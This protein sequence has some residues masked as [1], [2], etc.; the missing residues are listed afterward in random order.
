MSKTTSGYSKK[1]AEYQRKRRAKR[2]AEGLCVQCGKVKATGSATTGRRY[3]TCSNCRRHVTN[4]VAAHR[5]GV[6][7]N[8]PDDDERGKPHPFTT[9]GKRYRVKK[10]RRTGV[11]V[12]CPCPDPIIIQFG[13]KPNTR[14]VFHLRECE[15]VKHGK[16]VE[17]KHL[18][19]IVPILEHLKEVKQYKNKVH[20]IKEVL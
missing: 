13:E 12:P 16:E 5:E 4:R 18:I 15:E 10:T 20:S 11:I 19:G 17:R 1:Q 2:K 14:R 7:Y 3:L 9:T 8:D 6:V